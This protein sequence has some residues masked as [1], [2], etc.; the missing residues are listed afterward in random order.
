MEQ[1]EIAPNDNSPNEPVIKK[2]TMLTLVTVVSILIALGALFY[3]IE[4]RRKLVQI[5]TVSGT[6]N[7][8]GLKPAADESQDGN[9]ADIGQLVLFQKEESAADFSKVDTEI[10]FEDGATWSWDQAQAGETY[11]LKLQFLMGEK[12]IKESSIV[13]TTAPADGQTLSL[14]ITKDDIVSNLPEG[15]KVTIAGILDLNGYIPKGSKVTVYQK[16]DAESGSDSGS[17]VPIVADLT[18]VDQT[19]WSWDGA[20]A[21]KTYT[22]FA[23]LSLNN[24]TFGTSDEYE[25]VAPARDETLTIQSKV[26]DPDNI[27][28]AEISG[29]IKLKGPI[30]DDSSIALMQRK[31]GDDNFK[32]FQTV[33]PV[34]GATFKWSDATRGETYEIRAIFRVDGQDLSH[35]NTLEV[36]APARNEVLSLDTQVS[37]K[38]PDSKPIVDCGK[39]DD[40]GHWNATVVFPRIDKASVY[41]LQ[42][43]SKPNQK[44]VK[45]KLMDQTKKNDLSVDV[46]LKDGSK[47]YARYSYSHCKDC[48][49]SDKDNW[50][51]YSPTRGFV[52]TDSGLNQN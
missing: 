32:M 11:Q 5:V 4:T 15:T 52:C 38:S 37:L 46:Y 19:A 22:L 16:K 45:N 6:V 29:K 2:H 23:E 33:S 35:S 18:A 40:T 42:V 28:T 51:G 3:L 12:V 20:E 25:I 26:Q 41:A 47:Y 8:N 7:L 30:M 14:N 31:K 48:P 34:D 17:N 24:K 50:S 10:P 43:G 39:K 36:T 44:D 9:K 21:G 49:L 27:T 1:N 13:T